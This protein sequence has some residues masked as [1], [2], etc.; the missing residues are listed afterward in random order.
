VKIRVSQVLLGLGWI[1]FACFG[2][3]SQASSAASDPKAKEF[4]GRFQESGFGVLV[5]PMQGHGAPEANW[6]REYFQKI[7]ERVGKEAIAKAGIHVRVNI[8]SSDVPNAFATY[9]DGTLRKYL[10]MAEDGKPVY[11][12]GVL[13]GI[14][15][16]L[17]TEDEAAFLLGHELGHIILGDVE[18][19]EK[20]G[21]M[22]NRWYSAQA[23]EGRADLFALERMRGKYELDAAQDF[24]NRLHPG[25]EEVGDMAFLSVAMSSHHHGSV[26]EATILARVQHF[27]R[28]D[29]SVSLVRETPITSQLLIARQS[30]RSD[31]VSEKLA[32][33]RAEYFKWFKEFLHRPDGKLTIYSGFWRKTHPLLDSTNTFPAETNQL[34]LESLKIIE[35]DSRLSPL[36][37]IE[38]VL[39]LLTV[40]D[41]ALYAKEGQYSA[42]QAGNFLGQEE[43]ALLRD[44]I[45]RIQTQSGVTWTAKDLLRKFEERMEVYVSG[46]GD[47]SGRAVLRRLLG[48][49]KARVVFNRLTE[50]SKPW[51]DLYLAAF[52]F[53]PSQGLQELTTLAEQVLSYSVPKKLRMDI[54]EAIQKF[55]FK[56]ELGTRDGLWRVQKFLE[57]KKTLSGS[58]EISPEV[59]QA[60]EKMAVAIEPGYKAALL[61]EL[62]LALSVDPMTQDPKLLTETVYDIEKTLSHGRHRYALEP[63]EVGKDLALR[64]NR[65]METVES[66]KDLPNNLKYYIKQPA[67]RVEEVVA[68]GIGKG[69][70]PEPEARRLYMKQLSR[71]SRRKEDAY[72]RSFQDQELKRMLVTEQPSFLSDPQMVGEL[73]KLAGITP[74]QVR[75]I[76]LTEQFL[77]KVFAGKS[78]EERASW[79]D[80]YRAGI[81]LLSEKVMDLRYGRQR[82]ILRLLSDTAVR[83]RVLS[84]ISA[85]ELIKITEEAK[86]IER[87][88]EVVDLL[89]SPHLI[90]DKEFR[91]SLRKSSYSI[92]Q[93]ATDALLDR[94]IEL[95]SQGIHFEHWVTAC[96]NL[97]ERSRL[98]AN[99]FPIGRRE[100]LASF[101]DKGLQ[102]LPPGKKLGVLK[103]PGILSLLAPEKAAKHLAQG[104]LEQVQGL[105]ELKQKAAAFEAMQVELGL[106]EE[107]L[108]LSSLLKKQVAQEL[109]LQ[110]G[111]LMLFFSAKEKVISPDQFGTEVRG[112]SG[113]VAKVQSWAAEEQL[114]FLEYILGR[115]AKVPAAVERTTVELQKRLGKEVNFGDIVLQL[116]AKLSKE[117]DLVRALAI[118][119]FFT[120]NAAVTAKAAGR[121]KVVAHLLGSVSKEHQGFA[122]ELALG[123]LH[124]E[125]RTAPMALAV[126]FA[127]SGQG[128]G[129]LT[130]GEVLR[131]LFQAYGVP[132]V[133]FGQYLAFSSEMGP[134]RES[135]S[136]LQDNAM[137]LA[138]LE[139]IELLESKFPQGLPEGFKIL[140][141]KGSGSVNIGIEYFNS[142]NGKNEI[143]TVSR[144]GVEAATREDFKR[145]RRVLESLTSTPQ[146][147]ARYGFMLG[148]DE[149]IQ[150]SVELEFNRHQVFQN[151]RELSQAIKSEVKGW[152]VQLVEP[153]SIDHGVIRMQ[154]AEGVPARSVEE[155]NPKLYR[156]AM[157]AASDVMTA[158]LLREDGAAKKG[159]RFFADS[160]FHNGQVFIDAKTKSVWLID[161]G[162]AVAISSEEYEIAKTL[163]RVLSG[164]MDPKNGLRFI[165][166]SRLNPKPGTPFMTE[167]ELKGI[168]EGREMADAFIQLVGKV[169]QKGGRVPLPVVQ[170]VLGMNR[171]V[172]LRKKLGIPLDRRLGLKFALDT[173]GDLF[174][175]K[176]GCLRDARTLLRKMLDARH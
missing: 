52:R 53:E 141:V 34:F 121:E 17:K 20:P 169:R 108:Q 62:S 44:L 3:G 49:S 1:G 115:R 156:S 124:G 47:L 106:G 174:K 25:Q 139:A 82:L 160:D 125:G 15:P 88:S 134:L 42:I 135:L 171:Q 107:H 137:P 57:L 4:A 66:R 109:K 95:Q 176:P 128:G 16:Y 149:A 36:E 104:Y 72:L 112:Y 71:V 8:Y 67:E 26:R 65:W 172:A 58:N 114:E 12:I 144:D 32:E 22:A 126:V 168:I 91:K 164:T 167:A 54:K 146:G 29:P 86:R 162:Q 113:V 119:P 129:E 133:K 75:A 9:P 120:G 98:D 154:K 56:Q 2:V 96:T 92:D 14:Y 111:E 116:R 74:E 105:L 76:G 40:Y 143:M 138:Y 110:P 19:Q 55:D 27:K 90:P 127:Q 30:A 166:E 145:L 85:T 78:E 11:E 37:K 170:W 159:F 35:T 158:H 152:K 80:Q 33:K 81:E 21:D 97:L 18:K 103:R 163:L 83:K 157:E 64:L 68:Y 102:A 140:G 61:R 100:S 28:T 51:S 153:F 136:S 131:G 63:E 122:Q 93:E 79:V 161:P 130:E 101:L 5:T 6:A 46:N 41:H 60:V 123:I 142:K 148:L 94:L 155:S 38:R 13:Q 173:A 77:Q 69:Y 132:G 59:A 118:L 50:V 117:S 87:D 84:Q 89:R 24:I 165:N 151:H 31:R 70:W 175:G 7:L 23:T 150:E 10:G 39:E 147:K 43:L 48:G 99:L 73:A 45:R